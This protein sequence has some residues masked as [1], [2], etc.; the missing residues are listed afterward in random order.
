MNEA[1]LP[2]LAA[3]AR[4]GV[5]DCDIHPSTRSPDE[6]DAF[7]PTRWREHRRMFGSHVR[8][9]FTEVFPYPRMAPEVSRHDA[10][11]PG[12]GPPGSDLAFMRRQHLD[13]MGVECGMLIPLRTRAA[14]QRNLDFGAALC[15]AVNEWQKAAWLDPEPRLRGAIVVGQE[16]PEAAVEEIRRCAGDRRFSQVLLPPRTAEPLGRR[17]YRPIFRAA[18]EAGLPVALHVGGV[19]NHPVTGGGTPSFYFEEHHSNV[20]TMQAV[21]TSL[22]TEGVF[23]DIPELR[24]VLIESGF[25]WAA[26]L[27]W[28]LDAH[29]RTLKAEVPHLTLAPSE[30]IRR[31]I[32]F[33]TQPID[34]PDAPEDLLT[35]MEWVGWDRLMFS[36]DYPH[37]D[38]DDPRYAFRVRLPEERRAALFRGTAAAFYGLDT[39]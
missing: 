36:S 5:V 13:P 12:G 20:Q 3:S 38:Q 27:G 2:Q 19:A 17:R 21:V 30:Y 11:P 8:Q 23:E 14:D 1:L 25:S 35:A 24:I 32:W 33:T 18:A 6:I 29:W 26:T 15:T 7:L 10:W 16:W 9:A 31:H 37:W 39:A 4:T 28:R 22:V 34:E